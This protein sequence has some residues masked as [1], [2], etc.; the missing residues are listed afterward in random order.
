MID[1][2]IVVT[3][4]SQFNCQDVTIENDSTL[5]KVISNT[6]RFLELSLVF[7]C[8]LRVCVCVCGRCACVR[9]GSAVAVFAA[10]LLLATSVSKSVSFH[11]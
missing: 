5:F 4:K 6:S 9:A 3:L 1:R 8:V 2:I 11:A 7:G 10:S